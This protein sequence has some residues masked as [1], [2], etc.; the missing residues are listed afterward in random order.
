MHTMNIKEELRSGREKIYEY[1]HRMNNVERGMTGIEMPEKDWIQKPYF[2][3]EESQT[4]FLY[5]A[6]LCGLDRF[7]AWFVVALEPEEETDQ[8][9]STTGTQEL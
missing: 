5:L 3:D 8:N 7:E 9:S 1:W 4:R 2:P 6:E